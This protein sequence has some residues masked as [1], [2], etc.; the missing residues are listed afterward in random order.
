M[1]KFNL[2]LVL[3]LISALSQDCSIITNCNTCDT[4][5]GTEKCTACNN[6]N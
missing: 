4:A 5:N 3:L 1:L 2:L 6:D